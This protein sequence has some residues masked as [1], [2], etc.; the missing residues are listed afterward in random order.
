MGV[1]WTW[2]LAP[3]ATADCS[4]SKPTDDRK[5]VSVRL[6]GENQQ[7]I[8]EDPR[9]ICSG[10]AVAAPSP[11]LPYNLGKKRTWLVFWRAERVCSWRQCLLSTGFVP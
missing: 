4:K 3:L 1:T 7:G 11:R 6:Q 8:P 10:P 5:H 2:G 9:L